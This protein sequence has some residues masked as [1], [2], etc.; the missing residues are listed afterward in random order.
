MESLLGY[1]YIVKLKKK[2]ESTI[3]GSF[4]KKGVREMVWFELKQNKCKRIAT[5][6][7]MPH[8]D[9]GF[10]LPFGYFLFKF[11]FCIWLTI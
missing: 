3:L 1:Y 11:S 2:K 6:S 8:L 7:H 9:L 10:N 4:E 5:G